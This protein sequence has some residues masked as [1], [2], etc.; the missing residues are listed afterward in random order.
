GRSRRSLR[1]A[2]VALPAWR[3]VKITETPLARSR[4]PS[5]VTSWASEQLAHSSADR[6]ISALP[7][8]VI[9]STADFIPAAKSPWPMTIA[10]GGAGSAS[11]SELL[12]V[13]L[14]ILAHVGRRPHLRLEPLVEMR[15]R[16]HAAVLEEMVQRDHFG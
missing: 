6:A 9:L 1:A 14:Q 4:S 13:F 8:P 10:R 7:C 2:I 5:R 11:G 16:I 15:G 3:S 12:I